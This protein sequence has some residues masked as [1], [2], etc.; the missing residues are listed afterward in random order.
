MERDAVGSKEDDLTPEPYDAIFKR[1]N[2]CT[3]G[4]VYVLKIRSINQSHF[5]WMQEPS[6]E[7][8]VEISSKV[9]WKQLY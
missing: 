9:G 2:K 8:D 7:K 3:T 6:A 5:F 4:R 1:V